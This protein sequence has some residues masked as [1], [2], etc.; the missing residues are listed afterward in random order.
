MN[1]I[2]IGRTIEGKEFNEA[3]LVAVR[4]GL[5]GITMTNS[6]P[7]ADYLALVEKNTSV[8]ES[9]GF[10]LQRRID[11]RNDG[12][13]EVDV[14]LIHVASGQFRFSQT[15]LPKGEKIFDSDSPEVFLISF[16][17]YEG[18]LGVS[19]SNNI[20]EA[21]LFGSKRKHREMP[22]LY[23]KTADYIKKEYVDHTGKRYTKK[24][25]RKEFERLFLGMTT[26][27]EEELQVEVPVH[28]NFSWSDIKLFMRCHRCFYIKR[29]LRVRFND[30]DNDKFGLEKVTD[31][32]L[33]KEFD[34]YRGMGKQHPIVEKHLLRLLKD[35]RLPE[36][37]TPWSPVNRYQIKGVQYCDTWG[38]WMVYGVV[39]DLWLNDKK[40][41]V[42][43]DYK[44]SINGQIYPE[45]EKQLAF[46]AWIFR[47]RNYTVSSRAY[48]LMY[49]PLENRDSFD[50]RLEFEPTLEAIEIDDSW[51]QKVIFDALDCIS[52]DKLPLAGHQAINS[53]KKCSL[54]D[55]FDQLTLLKSNI[56]R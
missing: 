53:S 44:S 14:R 20:F 7:R 24:I 1:T 39:D 17:L 21:D 16:M 13:V 2:D 6:D 31:S 23:D 42:I 15:V 27:E 46:Y 36:W 8:L 51:V 28:R 38:N 5:G 48:L 47:K 52:S 29:K 55:Y 49:K 18:L 37:R 26:E 45:Y 19:S 50:W 4:L 9:C 56:Q 33:K 11:L 34:R 40:E 10:K 32:L 30:F 22:V 12:S 43:V 25:D 35:K 3:F 41:L 54:C